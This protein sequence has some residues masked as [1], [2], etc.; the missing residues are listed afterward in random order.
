MAI[1]GILLD[2]D[3]TLIDYDA[4]WGP[5]NRAAVEIG[6][7]GDAELA[8]R[9]YTVGGMDPE[10]GL[11]AAD[12]LFAAGHTREIAE[13]FVAAGSPFTAEALVTAFDELFVAGAASAVPVTDLPALFR[14]LAG[15]GYVLGIAS[16][17][18]ERAIHG[19]IEHFG[20][21]EH[22]GFVSGYDS[23]NGYK[24]GPGMA[25]AFVAAT[26][27]AP[28]EIAVVGDNLH[29]MAMGR[30]AGVGLCVGVLSGTGSRAR[31]AE[32]ADAVLDDVA[33]LPDWLNGRS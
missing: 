1:R 13:A 4:T 28:C 9:L 24:P 22:L 33:A 27:F 10:T 31:L 32:V 29:D 30:S 25:N 3:G 18:S 20:L 19:L 6:A 23:G 16:S 21:G 7:D 17:D 8:R 12:S 2:K 15:D 5:I 11:T 26:G 14:R